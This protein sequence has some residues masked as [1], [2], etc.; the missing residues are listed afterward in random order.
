MLLFY[1]V[2]EDRYTSFGSSDKEDHGG[3]NFYSQF[4]VIKKIF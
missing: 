1:L 3:N 2:S 4:Y